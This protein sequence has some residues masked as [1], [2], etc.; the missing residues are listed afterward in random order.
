MNKLSILAIVPLAALAA[1]NSGD[2]TA[3][4]AAANGTDAANAALPADNGAAPADAN[5]VAGKPTGD[6]APA[7]DSG[8]KPTADGNEA[9]AGAK[10]AGNEQ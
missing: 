3:E 9:E 8:A 10:P 2:S 7:G 1:C 5:A 4:N 6:G